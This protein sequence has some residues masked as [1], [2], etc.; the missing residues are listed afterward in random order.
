MSALD[1]API[2]KQHRPF[3]IYSSFA[4]AL[5]YLEE[6]W[7]ASS[8]WSPHGSNEASVLIV[9]VTLV[10]FVGY[11]L[12]FLVPPMLVAETWDHPR[13]WGV[14]SN[15]TA[16]SAGITV[17]VNALI[18]VL[19]LYLVSFNLVATYNL[20]RD[21]YIYTLVALLFFHGLLLYVR[22]MTYLY[23]TPGFV[24]PL[25]VVAAS[26]GIGMVILVVAGFLFTL[27][28]R[29]LELAPPAQE[30]MLGLHVYLRSLYLLTLIIAAYAWHLRWIA[31]H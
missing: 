9:L 14:L 2:L 16:W 27:D 8:F 28:L 7:S 25:K 21:I 19:L 20:L 12:S 1:L 31:D 29:R 30:G 5:L 17:A 23:Q 4:L 3:A 13:A 24:Q 6:A 22:Y 15:V 11:M 26:V 10:A 18:F